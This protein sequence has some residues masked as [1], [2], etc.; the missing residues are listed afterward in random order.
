MKMKELNIMFQNE[1]K[2]SIYICNKIMNYYNINNINDILKK[3]N[4]CITY[5]LQ[6][7]NVFSY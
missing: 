6:K 7:T 5:F 2:Y 1:I 4:T 3:N